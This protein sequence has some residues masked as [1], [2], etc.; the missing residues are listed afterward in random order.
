MNEIRKRRE[1]SEDKLCTP[2]S[3]PWAEFDTKDWQRCQP[4]GSLSF[5]LS[6]EMQ[7]SIKSLGSQQALFWQDREGWE[8]SW[9]LSLFR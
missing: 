6:P 8:A 7:P 4:C 2:D 3:L 1:N 5:S 9:K